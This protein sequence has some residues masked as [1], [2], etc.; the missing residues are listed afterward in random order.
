MSTTIMSWNT[1]G[2]CSSSK[3]SAVKQ[4]L[5]LHKP[6]IVVLQE[7]KISTCTNVDIAEICG[8]RSMGWTFQPSVG[9]S[10]GI[11]IIWNPI[12]IKVISS[13]EGEYSLSVECRFVATNFH[14][15]FTGVYGPNKVSERKFLWRELHYI[16]GLWEIPWVIG[17]DFNVIRRIEERNTSRGITHSMKKFSRFISIHA[18]IDPPLKGSKFTWSNGQASPV[19]SRIDRFIFSTDFEAKFPFV[20][21]LAKTR[22][23]SDH[24]P[25]VLDLAEPSWGPSPFRL[26]IMW[27]NH[28]S[29][30]E[31]IN[32][33]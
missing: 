22:A 18:L 32:A 7:S 29:F 17:G 26:E 16:R 23:T 14:W 33:W 8:S 3:R 24:I 2:L 11:I 13:L 4:V 12:V 5:H 30:L 6:S 9:A 28:P 20:S 15:F 19:L 1:R 10:G 27:F 31:N 21:Q 25:I